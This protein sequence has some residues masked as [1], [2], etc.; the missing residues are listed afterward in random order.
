MSAPQ[1][2]GDDWAQSLFLKRCQGRRM[3][4]DD[5]PPPYLTKEGLV[6]IDR[7]SHQ[8]RRKSPATHTANLPGQA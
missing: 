2:P 7:R 5:L 8:D 3:K 6:L 4:A 1:T